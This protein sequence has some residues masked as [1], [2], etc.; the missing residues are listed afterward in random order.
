MCTFVKP[1]ILENFAGRNFR[2]W[3]AGT[4]LRKN[5]GGRRLDDKFWK[6]Y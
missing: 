2:K 3:P 4:V 5:S 1:E 6:D